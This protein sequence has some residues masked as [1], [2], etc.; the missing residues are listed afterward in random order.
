MGESI[1]SCRVIDNLWGSPDNLRSSPNIL[2]DGPEN[3]WSST[4]ILWGS[5][6]ILWDS[7]DLMDSSGNLW[8]SP[9]KTQ[10]QLFWAAEAVTYIVNQHPQIAII[11]VSIQSS[12][13]AT[14]TTSVCSV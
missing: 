14:S 11:K 4:N 9:K 5:P 7:Y 2:R 12:L 1:A 10:E 8:S 13:L 6:D 3:L